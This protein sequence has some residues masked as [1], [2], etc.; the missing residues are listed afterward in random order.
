VLATATVKPDQD[1]QHLLNTYPE[2]AGINAN[3]AKG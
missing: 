3:N 1:G 2:A